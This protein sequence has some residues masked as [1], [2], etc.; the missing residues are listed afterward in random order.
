M[1]QWDITEDLIMKKILMMLSLVFVVTFLACRPNPTPTPTPTTCTVTFW[2]SDD[3]GENVWVNLWDNYDYDKERYIVGYYSS[4]PGCDAD[5]CANFYDL[6]PGD[7]Y[8]E[9]ENSYYEW[10]GDLRVKNGCNTYELFVSRA[11][12]KTN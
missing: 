5:D 10:E 3:V 4:N 2:T 11:R 1:A 9:A 7:Y 8:F 12:A 6:E